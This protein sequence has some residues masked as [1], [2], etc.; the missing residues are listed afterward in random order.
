MRRQE[1]IEANRAR[2]RARRSSTSTS[3]DAAEL[4]AENAGTTKPEDASTTG[5]DEPIRLVYPQRMM[6]SATDY[7]SIAIFD[8]AK[9]TSKETDKNPINLTARADEIEKF[10]SDSSNESYVE[11]AKKLQKNS[12]YIILP[13]PQSVS[14]SVAVDYASDTINPLQV[15]GLNATKDFML[16]GKIDLGAIK[17]K[18]TNILTNDG[19]NKI[20]TDQ[21]INLLATALA[22]KAIN[23]LGANVS[24]S[25]LI[26]RSQGLILQ[27]N[28]EL[29]FSGV[30]LRSFPFIFDFAPRDYDEAVMVKDI[31]R[32]IK[33]SMSPRRGQ[34]PGLFI[35]S[36]KLF[37]FAYNHRGRE[38]PFLNKMKTGFLTS[39]NVDYT[40]SGTYA[41]YDDGTPVHMRMTLQFTEMNPIYAEDY[42]SPAA[43]A[44]GVGY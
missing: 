6:E 18:V 10:L 12:R 37:K 23:Q 35:Q 14:D 28:L 31:I 20:L 8:Y 34:Y 21:N 5:T 36:P 33:Q 19:K 11:K 4:A 17:S 42:D 1:L 9:D 13:I 40:A 3:D 26:S 44:L 32:V 7:L 16:N 22:G 30:Q 2:A 41:T 27:S 29:L 38:H 15:A 24:V 39:M 43:G 25:S